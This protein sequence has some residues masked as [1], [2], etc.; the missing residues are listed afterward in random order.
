MAYELCHRIKAPWHQRHGVN[1]PIPPPLSPY[2]SI[3]VDFVT[4]L[5][6]SLGI[7]MVNQCTSI[8]V[9]ID[10]LTKMAIYL[11]CHQDIDS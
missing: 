3:T 9:I 6:L 1:M 4:N 11:P 8:L 2:G 10:R 7:D 5:P